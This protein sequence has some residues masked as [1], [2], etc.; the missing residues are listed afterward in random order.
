VVMVVED[1]GS[2]GVLMEGARARSKYFSLPVGR[3]LRNLVRH[4]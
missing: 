2:K 4:K 3:R 1:H